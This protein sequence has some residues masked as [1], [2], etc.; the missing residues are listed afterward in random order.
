[1]RDRKEKR[2]KPSPQRESN[3]L[4]L[5][6]PPRPLQRRVNSGIKY[7]YRRG[8]RIERLE[9]QVLKTEIELWAKKIKAYT[10]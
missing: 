7:S 5:E 1:M 10:G 4:P 3:V 6:L 9:K 2:K 8:A